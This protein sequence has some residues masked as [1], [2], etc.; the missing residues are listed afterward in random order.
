MAGA[1]PCGG[2]RVQNGQGPGGPSRTT[3]RGTGGLLAGGGAR[4]RTSRPLVF[5]CSPD[6]PCETACSPSEPRP[7]CLFLVHEDSSFLLFSQV[8][9]LYGI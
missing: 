6:L 2:R 4:Q 5:P 1:S 3:L 8:V 7:T 9:A